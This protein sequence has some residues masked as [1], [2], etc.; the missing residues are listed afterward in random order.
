MHVLLFATCDTKG[1][2]AT[3]LKGQLELRG[4]PTKVVDCGSSGPPEGEVDISREELFAAAGFSAQA[5]MDGG[6]RGKAV[7]AA[8][9]GAA[10][11]A[12]GAASR[13]ELSGV[14]GIGGSAGT[15]IGTAAMRALP[16]GLP[17]LM[18]ST[19]ASGNM[20]PYVGGGDILVMNSVVDFAGMNRVSRQV[21][22]QAVNAMAGMVTLERAQEPSGEQRPLVATTMFG[23][24][25]AC[26]ERAA[27]VLDA[28]GYE[29][30]VFHATGSGG[31]SFELLVRSGMLAG[32]LDLTTTELADELV[33]GILSAGPTRL[34]AAGEMGLPQVVSVGATD[35]VN[36][37]AR[38]S[39]PPRFADRTVY[40]HNEN[41]TLMRTTSKECKA[42]GAEI[43]CKL[44]AGK[45]PRRILLPARG[46]SAID[47]DEAPFDDPAARAALFAGIEEHRGDV[48]C[49]TLDLHIN[50]P[51]FAEAAAR[52]LLELMQHE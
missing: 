42:I 51:E 7:N 12:L 47:R 29:V 52:A 48:E 10:A 33:G 26:V 20:R 21:L 32:V 3:W 13:N 31:E 1:R 18:V 25:T 19:L 16:M 41:V 4:V 28:A 38:A 43:G 5:L 49:D 23:V 30:L 17:K 45:G 9:S 11:L 36:F 6:E 40:E 50:D 14:L 27:Q 8:A 2:E 15:T 34:T 22:G 24:T 35:M 37:G 39:L 46:V 44:A